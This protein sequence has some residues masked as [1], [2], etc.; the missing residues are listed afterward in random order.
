M[1]FAHFFLHPVATALSATTSLL[2]FTPL[3]TNVRPVEKQNLCKVQEKIQNTKYL[4]QNTNM[5]YHSL[6]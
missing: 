4:H 3:G 1:K 5:N 2:K 6:D